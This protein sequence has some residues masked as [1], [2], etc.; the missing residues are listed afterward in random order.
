MLQVCLTSVSR[1]TLDG[2]DSQQAF[3]VEHINSGM[4]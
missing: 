1:E 2:N 4:S 3:H